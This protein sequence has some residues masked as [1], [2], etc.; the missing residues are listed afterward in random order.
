MGVRRAGA[1]LGWVRRRG[2]GEG[3]LLEVAAVVC[4]ENSLKACTVLFTWP[5]EV[6]VLGEVRGADCST[7]CD[8][9]YGGTNTQT[10]Y[11]GL[12]HYFWTFSLVKIF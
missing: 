2:A 7:H 12:V 10:Q 4:C 1:G 6:T 11:L 3:G 9:V 5:C 8:Q